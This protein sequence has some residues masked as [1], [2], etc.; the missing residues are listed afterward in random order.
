MRL[1]SKALKKSYRPQTFELCISGVCNP[2]PGGPLSYIHNPQ[3]QLN[4]P[5]TS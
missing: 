3:P 2:A 1:L 4:T 5:E